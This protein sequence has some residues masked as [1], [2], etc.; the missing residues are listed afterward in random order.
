MVDAFAVGSVLTVNVKIVTLH[1]VLFR[2][3][4]KSSHW[5]VFFRTI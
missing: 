1:K 4:T 3:C 2:L 5:K